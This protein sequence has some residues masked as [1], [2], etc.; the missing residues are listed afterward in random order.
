MQEIKQAVVVIIAAKAAIS[1][2][3]KI[4]PKTLVAAKVIAKS[5]TASKMVIRTAPSQTLS[6]RQTHSS[7]QPRL[8]SPAIKASA[9]NATAIPKTTH[10]K[11]G[12]TVI[13]AIY[14]N[15]AAV[16]PIIMLAARAIIVQSFLFEQLQLQLLI[17]SP[18]L[19]YM[20]VNINLSAPL[21]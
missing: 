6:V 17:F 3:V 16:M 4:A 19:Q 9:K 15:I 11:A 1:T 2:P 20:S 21:E 13:T 14:L 10:K 12:V 8:L 5:T 18:P 7:A